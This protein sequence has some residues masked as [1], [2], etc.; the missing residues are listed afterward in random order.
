MNSQKKSEKL[1]I[2][3]I[4]LK[5][6]YPPYLD[7]GTLPTF[8]LIKHLAA[9]GHLIHLLCYNDTCCLPSDIADICETIHVIPLPFKPLA[10][11]Q[12]I[13]THLSFR[14]GLINIYTTAG[15][16]NEIHRVLSHY[17]IDV[18]HTNLLWMAKNTW[19]IK[20]YPKLVN[21]IDADSLYYYR[22]FRSEKHP[23][24]KVFWLGEYFKTRYAES[25]LYPHFDVCSVVSA[26][27]KIHLSRFLR[28]VP[29]RVA[30]NGVDTQYFSPN[31]MA[32]EFPSLIFTGVMDYPPNSNGIIYFI[33]EILPHL[34]AH[35]PDLM[36]YIVGRRPTA[37]LMRLASKHIRVTGYVADLRHYL[38]KASVYVCPLY[39]G[40]G[41]KNKLLE[42]MSMSKAIVATPISIEGLPQAI[43]GQHVCIAENRDIIIQKIIELLRSPERRRAL[44]RNARN[45]MLR[46]FSWQ[47]TSCI[48]E[49]AYREAIDRHH[50]QGVNAG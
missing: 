34:K 38:E 40:T 23:L 17:E 30:P 32:E 45:L 41:I 15:M 26:T 29:I 48:F 3:F 31:G 39:S 27:D 24:K 49:K 16:V 42:A 46:E 2:L 50:R 9:R 19:R 1:N 43:N 25:I 35:Y 11:I 36:L 4:T 47:Q 21:A 20:G 7:G 8:M 12:K 10:T 22:N 37:E 13:G 5:I 18:I 14:P 44:G 6:P 28:T 33:Q